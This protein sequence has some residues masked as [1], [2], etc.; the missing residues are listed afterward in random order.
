[1]DPYLQ[2]SVRAFQIS[3]NQHPPGY[4]DLFSTSMRIPPAMAD[5]ATPI[6]AQVPF[7]IIDYARRLCHSLVIEGI[8]LVLGEFP[9]GNLSSEKDI[10]FLVRA[11]L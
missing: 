2:G 4:H 10:K 11:A 7:P 1:M 9:S 5:R 3:N 6:S 8:N